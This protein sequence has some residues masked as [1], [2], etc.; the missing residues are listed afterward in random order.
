[1]SDQNPIGLAFW[2][3]P[4]F[5]TAPKECH[6]HHHRFP[7]RTPTE[8][9]EKANASFKAPGTPT[10][11]PLQPSVLFVSGSVSAPELG[12]AVSPNTTTP[13]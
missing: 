3:H 8:S 12:L 5:C 11:D 10:A 7:A 4:T 2:L 13:R 1:M 6:H 9:H